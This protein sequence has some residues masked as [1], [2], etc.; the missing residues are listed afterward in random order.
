[1]F[2][3][4]AVRFFINVSFS[5]VVSALWAFL[6]SRHSSAL[7]C[8]TVLYLCWSI[9][10]SFIHLNNLGLSAHADIPFANITSYLVSVI[11]LCPQYRQGRIK[12]RPSRSR[13]WFS[14]N[15]TNQRNH[16]RNRKDFSV[17]SE[18]QTCIWPSWCHCHSLSLASVKSGLVLA[19]W[20]R[21]QCRVKSPCGPPQDLPCGPLADSLHAVRT[22]GYC[23]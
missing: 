15:C 11:I 18:V 22:V 2:C 8:F 14:R 4:S 1:M 5:A 10:Y 12:R 13:I 23:V 21:L 19:F 7:Y 17:W 9:K 16:N 20:Y 3:F 6:S